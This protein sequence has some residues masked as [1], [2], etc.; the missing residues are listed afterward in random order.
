MQEMILMSEEREDFTEQFKG[1]ESFLAT[2]GMD[3]V[4][5]G[6]PV[7]PITRGL[8]FPAG[9][10]DWQHLRATE[11]DVTK[12]SKGKFKDGGVGILTGV[13]PTNIVAIDIDLYDDKTARDMVLWLCSKTNGGPVRFGNRPKR[14][15]LFRSDKP[16]TKSISDS[17]IDEEGRLNRIEVLGAGQQFVSYGIHP[18]T[19]APYEWQFD[20]K[21]GPSKTGAMTLEV[22]DLPLISDLFD[23]FQLRKPKSWKFNAGQSMGHYIDSVDSTVNSTVSAVGSGAGSIS[24]AGMDIDFANYKP[25]L[26]IDD[27][28]V[29]LLLEQIDNNDHDLWIRMG[30]AVHHQYNGSPR[31]MQIWDEWSSDAVS[32]K[33]NDIPRRWSSFETTN[34]TNPITFASVIKLGNKERNKQI[35]AMREGSGSFVDAEGNVVEE[36]L[37][38]FR[39]RFVYVTEGD[40]VHDLEVPAQVA[41]YKMAEFR[42]LTANKRHLV[43]APT[44]K[45]PEKE[46]MIPVSA[47]WLIDEERLEARA[48]NYR[49]NAG[50]IITDSH[51]GVV[52]VNEYH[53]P[54]WAETTDT[55]QI[56]VALDHF[57]YLF[58]SDVERD[59][60]LGWIADMIQKPERRCL[61]HP[62]VVSTC[63]GSGRG[64]IAVLVGRLLGEWNVNQCR[65]SDLSGE[66]NNFNGFLANNIMT[67]IGEVREK[68][69]ARFSISDKV[70]DVFTEPRLRVNV[71]HKGD[72]TREVFTRF[73]LQS[74]HV[75][76][77]AL[78]DEDRRINV[79]TGPKR[80][81]AQSRGYY[82]T[83]YDWLEGEGV[84]QLYYWMKRKDNSGFDFQHSFDTPGKLK[85]IGIGRSDTEEAFMDFKENTQYEFATYQQIVTIIDETFDD[86]SGNGINTK[87]ISH[88]LKD[89]FDRPLQGSGKPLKIKVKGHTARPFFL[90]RKHANMSEDW[91]VIRGKLEQVYDDLG[92]VI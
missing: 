35:M 64:W 81:E 82:V 80:G 29:E 3:L 62:L 6:Y 47:S 28:Q 18:D 12:W 59:W 51:T 31:G 8:K 91:D 19:Q 73:F 20:D 85:M 45:E 46:K 38:Q 15:I 32:Y 76:A 39:R 67:S 54:I 77:L 50:R 57:K 55:D 4:K 26:D 16:F 23:Y 75:D 72:S 1:K 69:D 11:E 83:L 5:N 25:K 27:A 24:N 74:N 49:P 84:R 9:L 87:M 78:D 89:H 44:D 86:N 7:L 92:G 88:L 13:S 68:N 61:V 21:Y 30:M 63:H 10:K 71:K 42:N 70:R 22:V 53:T 66:N 43:P 37:D 52:Y 90:G 34:G 65:F 17:Y 60:M 14:L 36:S 33:P 58:K 2:K 56:A 79:I 41:M 40:L 48:T